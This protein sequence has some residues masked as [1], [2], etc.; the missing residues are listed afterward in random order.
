MDKI[1]RL[2]TAIFILLSVIVLFLIGWVFS[3]GN[4][5]N[6]FSVLLAYVVILAGPIGITKGILVMIDYNREHK[7]EIE[8]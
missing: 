7:E 8:E 4:F 3:A 2:L 5:N 1:W 6:F